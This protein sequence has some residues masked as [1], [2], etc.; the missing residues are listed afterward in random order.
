LFRVSEKETLFQ[1]KFF[2][3]AMNDN[4]EIVENIMQKIICRIG[5]GR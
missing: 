5:Q 4:F 3:W 2:E 1:G